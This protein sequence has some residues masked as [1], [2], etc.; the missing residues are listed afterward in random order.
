MKHIVGIGANV[1]DTLIVAPTFPAE[2]RKIRAESIRECGGGP[3]AT[4]LVTAAK[5]GAHA[6]YLGVLADD[7]GGEFLMR[8]MKRFGVHCDCV[9]IVPG[10]TSFSS[11]VLLAKDT[12]SRTCVACRANSPE[13]SLDGQMRAA[14]ASADILMIDGNETDAAVEGAKV[15]RENGTAVLYDA[16][17]L[18]DGVERLLSLTDILIPSAEF[19]CAKAGTDDPAAAAKLLFEKYSPRVVIVTCGK[20]GGVLYDGGGVWHY[21]ALPAVVADSNGA[22]DV[23]HGAMAYFLTRSDDF[24]LGCI[25]ASAVSALKCTKIGARDGVPALGTVLNYLKE[26]GYN[27]FQKIMEQ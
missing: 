17:G 6:A 2:D 19:A 22:G 25:F 4:G 13:L 16:G 21:P 5:L 18:Y 20:S 15:A 23:F 8:D 12:S 24:R 3:C 9:R 14:I 27:E 10:T 1:Y 7:R 11:F 26:N